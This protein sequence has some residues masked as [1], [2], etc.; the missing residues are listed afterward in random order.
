M[1]YD[2]IPNGKKI[3]SR[4]NII[5]ED[6]KYCGKWTHFYVRNLLS[7]ERYEWAEKM[8]KVRK[9]FECNCEKGKRKYNHIYKFAGNKTNLLFACKDAF[10]VIDRKLWIEFNGN[11][12][13]GLKRK[14]VDLKIQV[15]HFSRRVII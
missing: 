7:N 9:C 8:F 6:F 3:G 14:G 4:M 15:I 1:F 5:I 12:W 2:Y 11:E 10:T 13:D